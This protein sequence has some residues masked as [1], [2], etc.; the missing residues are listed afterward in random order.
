MISDQQECL[1][2]RTELVQLIK[3]ETGAPLT[4]SHLGKDAA[5]GIGPKPAAYFGRVHLY[6]RDEGLRYARELMTSRPR[7]LKEREG[8]LDT[9]SERG[10]QGG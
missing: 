9:Q 7:A 10:T 3:D 8:H 5:K 4:K 6:T 1:Y 2:T